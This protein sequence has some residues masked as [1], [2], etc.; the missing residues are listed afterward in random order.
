MVVSRFCLWVIFNSTEQTTSRN[1]N[2]L[3]QDPKPKAK[4]ARPKLQRQKNVKSDTDEEGYTTIDEL[5]DKQKDKQKGAVH[6]L[7][8]QIINKYILKVC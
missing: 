3:P 5:D 1:S 8:E 2:A 6:R 7:G 4:A